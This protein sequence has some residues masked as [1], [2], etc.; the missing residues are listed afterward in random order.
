MN[1]TQTPLTPE[2]FRSRNLSLISKVL[3]G[4]V[5]SEDENAEDV[6]GLVNRVENRVWGIM[7]ED[8]LLKRLGRDGYQVLPEAERLQ[9]LEDALK[10]LDAA[11]EADK[12][13]KG[14]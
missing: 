9:I 8:P 14:K 11:Q 5:N 4:V 13:L 3:P 6:L 7:G 1:N 10:L 12:F 2:I